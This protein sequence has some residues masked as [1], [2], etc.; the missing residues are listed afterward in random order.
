MIDLY[1]KYCETM[2]TV[3]GA[4][5]PLPTRESWNTP[6]ASRRRPLTDDEFDFN[7][8]AVRNGDREIFG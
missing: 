3:Y 8:E 4:N 2:R 7:R 5:V 6:K 1:A